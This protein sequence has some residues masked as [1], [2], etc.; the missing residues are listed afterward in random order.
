M[1]LL[2]SCVEAYTG[3]PCTVINR[4]TSRYRNA[5]VLLP[6][7]LWVRIHDSRDELVDH[8]AA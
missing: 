2:N 3:P 4:L 7:R 6:R 5:L 1:L 8:L